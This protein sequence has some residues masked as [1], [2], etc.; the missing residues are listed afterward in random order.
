L[1]DDAKKYAE[2]DAGGHKIRLN[3]AEDGG[4]VS[5]TTANGAIIDMDDEEDIITLQTA[6]ED[7]G[8]KVN[9]AVLN[10]KDKVITLDSADNTV[11]LNGKETRITLESKDSKVAID[12]NGKKIA[13]E[14]K[15]NKVVIDGGSDTVTL[16]AKKDINIK[17]GGKIIL[18]AKNGISNKGQMCD[19]N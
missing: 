1:F 18:D 16:N 19:T 6:A 3:Y 9:L 12:G 5:V 15:K 14:N 8:K 11:V 2:I 17:A 7:G 10:G 4:R 13:M